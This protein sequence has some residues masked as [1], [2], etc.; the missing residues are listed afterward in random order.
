MPETSSGVTE[1]DEVLTSGLAVS[2][3]ENG[4]LDLGDLAMPLLLEAG[5]K[6]M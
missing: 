5:E 3:R 2:R 6:L 4:F 1:R